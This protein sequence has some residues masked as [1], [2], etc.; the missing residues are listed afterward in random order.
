M[1]A[2]IHI[3]FALLFLLAHAVRPA[4]VVKDECRSRV[5]AQIPA[6]PCACARVFSLKYPQKH[7][8]VAQPV[9]PATPAI[10]TCFGA[11]GSR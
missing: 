5:V 1:L 4:D 3:F 6:P 2:E 11:H 7:K 10:T 9:A 8:S